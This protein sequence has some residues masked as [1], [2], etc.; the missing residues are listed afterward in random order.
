MVTAVSGW[1]NSFFFQDKSLGISVDRTSAD[2]QV[3]A[4]DRVDIL[5][6]TAAGSFAPI[7]LADEVLIKGHARLPSAPLQTSE[8]LVGGHEDGQRISVQGTVHAERLESIWGHSVLVMDVDLGSGV[9]ASV[10]V[11]TFDPLHLPQWVGAYARITG[12]CGTIFN[13]RHQFIGVRMFVPESS[14]VRV[15]RSAPKVPF[16]RPALPL[17][18]LLQ[19]SQ[20]NRTDGLI[21]VSGIVTWSR[22]GGFYLQD[23]DRGLFVEWKEAKQP[24]VGSL[25]EAVGYAMVGHGS[26]RLSALF[27]RRLGDASPIH[28]RTVQAADVITARDGFSVTAPES[29]LIAVEGYLL[30]TVPGKQQTT[31]LLEDDNHTV[32]SARVPPSIATSISPGAKLRVT[33]VCAIDYDDYTNKPSA[34]FLQTRSLADIEVIDQAPW[35]NTRHAVQVSEGLLL[36]VIALLAVMLLSRVSTLR[37]LA[38]T[39]SL[40]GLSNRRMTVRTIEALRRSNRRRGQSLLLLFIDVNHFKEIN[41]R[42]GHR[43]GDVALTRVARLLEE[44]FPESNAIGRIGGDEFVVVMQKIGEEACRS[45]IDGALHHAN[46]TDSGAIQLSLSIGIVICEASEQATV[47]DLL[48]RADGLMY[49]EKAYSRVGTAAAS[50]GVYHQ[51]LCTP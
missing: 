30:D 44:A 10:R 25:T 31:L 35:W 49:R 15:L 27:V 24:V 32:F 47:E 42:Y 1:K 6:K 23:N 45:R 50:A 36:L 5:G 14:G 48:E 20:F 51:Q 22:T 43:C 3:E 39:D 26:T 11:R 21:R 4:G 38:T 8:K 28:A 7:V 40:T 19:F 16:E 13:D 17:D 18:A 33:G 46:T 2:P 29:Q 9:V 41:D 37:S 12:I 34:F